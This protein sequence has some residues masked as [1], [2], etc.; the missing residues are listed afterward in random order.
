MDLDMLSSNNTNNN[1][2]GMAFNTGIVSH[3][4]EESKAPVQYPEQYFKQMK[5][6]EWV[7]V[8]S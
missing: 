3:L 1:L 4:E 6:N 7:K 5:V 8:H 2:S